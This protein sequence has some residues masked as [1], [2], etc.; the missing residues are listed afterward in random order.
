M[1]VRLSGKGFVA[2]R[3]VVVKA[4]LAGVVRYLVR[5]GERI[6]AGTPLCT[7][8]S[9]ETRDRLEEALRQR[10]AELKSLE[11]ANSALAEEARSKLSQAYHE[12]VRSL[13][14]ISPVYGFQD[15]LRR[16]EKENRV[17]LLCAEMARLREFVE[18]Y[19][20]QRSTIVREIARLEQAL[21][22]AEVTVL[23]PE[24]GV[25]YRDVDGLEGTFPYDSVP[26]AAEIRVW[27]DQ[28]SRLY[29]QGPADGDK[30]SSGQVL[31]KIVPEDTVTLLLPVATEERPDLN[32]GQILTVRTSGG[33]YQGQV[34]SVVDGQP[35]GYSVICVSVGGL[36]GET[37]PRGLDATVVA[38]S[39]RGFIVPASALIRKNGTAGVLAV[40]KTV[41]RFE[42]VEV[43]LVRGKEALIRGIPQGTQICLRAWRFLEGK[44]V[45]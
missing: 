28:T 35:P 45:R 27:L 25:F 32:K 14:P 15:L 42:P 21:A 33:E 18:S 4:P 43:V 19:E 26:S 13:M 9:R 37:F 44:R 40:H 7:I 3:E 6:R 10:Q 24:A 30:V 5:S 36:P 38:F 41:A 23:A 22:W 8:E 20:E 1:E 39:S 34:K 11:R 29:P 12:A 16:E 17:L 31:G 2:A